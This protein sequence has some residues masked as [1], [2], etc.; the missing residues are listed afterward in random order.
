MSARSITSVGVLR[1]WCYDLEID[2]FAKSAL[3]VLI[4]YVDDDGECWPSVARIAREGGMSPRKARTVIRSL[5]SAGHLKVVHS[6]K[7]RATNRYKL[8]NDPAQPAALATPN[9]AHKVGLNPAQR[10]ASQNA[11]PAPQVSQPGTAC[12]LLVR[13]GLR[14]AS[15]EGD[16]AG[17][18]AASC[19]EA[20][21]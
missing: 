4:Q 9:P 14:E 16:G 21:P 3:H 7:G 11:N 20:T 12:R 8:I 5:E 1:R 17:Y 19:A 15:Q 6:S 2:A 18:R 10:A 13:N